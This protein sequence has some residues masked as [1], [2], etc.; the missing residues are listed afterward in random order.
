MRLCRADEL[1]LEK[2][3][4]CGQCFRWNIDGNGVYT[5]VAF[6]R[7]AEIWTEDGIVYIDADE[8]D[9][10]VWYEYFDLNLDYVKASESFYC[11]E[12]MGKCLEFGRGIR[13]LRQDRWE[14][15]CSFIISQ[16]NNIP[17]IKKIVEALCKTFGEPIDY[18]GKT[19]YSFPS[20]E[21]VAQLS[22]SNLEPIRCG[23]RSPYIIGAA[24][25]VADGVLNFSVL[26][27]MN[28]SEALKVVRSIHG[29]G[30]KVANCFILFGLHKMEAFPIDVWM[31][32]ALNENFPE[33]FDPN[34]FGE[35]AG[36]AQ[37][38]IFY[39]ARSG[40]NK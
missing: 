16:C 18:K 36:L 37:Q 9:R 13:I 39:Y 17:R 3:F 32:R 38:Y 19:Y 21:T 15:M 1:D 10:A 20:A 24:R 2:T 35:F 7:A 25:A 12:Y 28:H 34:T 6:G 31:K 11:S 8:E 33:K 26:D 40:D 4:E 27:K 14:A 30:E 29:V 22:E 23:Y 5:G